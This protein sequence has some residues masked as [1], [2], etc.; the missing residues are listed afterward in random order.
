MKKVFHLLLL[1]AV[2]LV[3][4]CSDNDSFTTSSS[5][6]LAFSV[7]TVMFD[8]VFSRVPSSTR[9]FWVFNHSGDGIRCSNVR[10]QQGNQTGFR[11]NVDGIY[12]GATEGYQSSDIEVRNKDSLR[13]FVELTSPLNNHDTPQLLEDHLVFTLESGVEQKV[14]LRAFTWDA[15]DVGHLVVDRDTTICSTRPILVSGGIEVAHGATLRLLGTT[16]YFHADAGIDV[17]GTLICD[18]DNGRETILRGDRLD[19]M[20]DYLPYDRVSGQWQGI[21]LHNTS[22]GNEI[23]HTHMHSGTNGIVCDSSATDRSKLILEYSTI[24][25][26][27]GYGLLARNS[28]VSINTCEITNTLLDCLS[29]CG[30]NVSLSNSTLAQFYPFDSNRGAALRLTNLLEGFSD[31]CPLEQFMA[32]NCIITGYADDVFMGEP[33]DSLA[34]NYLFDHCLLRTPKV[35]TDDSIFYA[36]VIYEDPKDTLT[37]AH[38]NFAN[39]DTDNLIYD[40]RLSKVSQAV[41]AADAAHSLPTDRYGYRRDEHPDMGCFELEEP[42]D[43]KP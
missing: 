23:R 32:R 41:N 35:E 9:T 22:F 19:H 14:N 1:L 7:D 6:R 20:F 4:A 17:Y 10:L 2:V 3:E 27:Q 33:S 12:L 43:Q 34:F 42:L 38:K 28:L 39:I 5:N 25:N 29:V 40:F 11:V 15:E 13:V 30:G 21:V 8:T 26:M 36:H 18:A 24:H 16:L 31:S 37:S